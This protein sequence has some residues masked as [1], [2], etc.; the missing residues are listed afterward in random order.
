MCASSSAIHMGVVVTTIA[1]AILHPSS[2]CKGYWKLSCSNKSHY[3]C[4]LYAD[5]V[6]CQIHLMCVLS[7]INTKTAANLSHYGI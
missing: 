3:Y 5:I 2:D 1:T 6:A 7:T 4:Y